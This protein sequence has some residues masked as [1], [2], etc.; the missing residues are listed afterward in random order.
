[1]YGNSTVSEMYG[2]SII[3]IPVYSSNSAKSIKFLSDNAII[4]VLNK[5]KPIIY[6]ANKEVE[7]KIQKG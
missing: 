6:M 5:N 3:T 2:N 4:R 7:L 1:M